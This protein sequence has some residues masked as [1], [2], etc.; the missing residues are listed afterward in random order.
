MQTRRGFLKS[1]SVMAG[2]GDEVDFSIQFSA[3]LVKSIDA[4]EALT[5]VAGVHPGCF[6][7]FGNETVRSITDLR[8]KKVGVQGIGSKGRL[9]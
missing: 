2:C 3:S 6:E 7:L 4:G 5:M 8:G 9:T 1:A